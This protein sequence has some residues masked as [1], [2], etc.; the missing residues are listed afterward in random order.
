MSEVVN[1]HK[2]HFEDKK[3]EVKLQL[4]A[5]PV[6]TVDKKALKIVFNN[7]IGNALRYSPCGS[8][9]TNETSGPAVSHDV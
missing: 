5:S 3:C 7:L 2:R 4:E 8:S 6:L 9:L 1:D